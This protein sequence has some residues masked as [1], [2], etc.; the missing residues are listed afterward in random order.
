MGQ[1]D[2]VTDQVRY[3]SDQSGHWSGQIFGCPALVMFWSWVEPSRIRV[4][5][6]FQKIQIKSDFEPDRSQVSSHFTS[7]KKFE[8]LEYRSCNIRCDFSFYLRHFRKSI[9][10]LFSEYVIIFFSVWKC[11]SFWVYLPTKKNEKQ[12]RFHQMRNKLLHNSHMS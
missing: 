2:R 9:I 12:I 10:S 11:G 7:S 8:Q 1:V 5:L 6:F 4:N 3:G